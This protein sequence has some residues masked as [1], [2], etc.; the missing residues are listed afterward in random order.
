MYKIGE[1]RQVEEL[2]SSA[3]QYMAAEY[4]CYHQSAVVAAWNVYEDKQRT[5]YEQL[6]MCTSEERQREA[7]FGT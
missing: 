4:A 3:T 2:A 7:W 6:S 5:T 1:D